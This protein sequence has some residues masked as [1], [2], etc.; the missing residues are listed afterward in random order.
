MTQRSSSPPARA[1]FRARRLRS[2]RPDLE[3]LEDRT[4]PAPLSWGID[5]DPNSWTDALDPGDPTNP[6][7]PPAVY[8][9]GAGGERH[10]GY[11]QQVYDGRRPPLVARLQYHSGQGLRRRRRS[12]RQR[13]PVRRFL[14]HADDRLA[15]THQPVVS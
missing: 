2:F 1:R 7:R 12:L 14:R 5:A 9:D 15:N 10:L 6:N 11:R 4:L 13:V 8:V 3:A